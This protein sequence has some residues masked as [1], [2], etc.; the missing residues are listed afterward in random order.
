MSEQDEPTVP[1]ST[2]MDEIDPIGPLLR[3]AGP[4]EPVPVDR[5][6]RMR[7]AVHAE[8]RQQTRA[9]SRRAAFR[10]SLG[11]V[12]AA[13]LVLLGVRLTVRGGPEVP[14][15]GPPLAS[16]EAVNGAVRLVPATDR[17]TAASGTAASG[18]AALS[19][20]DAGRGIAERALVRVGDAVRAGD[21]VDTTDGGLAALR[22]AS[23]VAVR[24]DRETRLRLLSHVTLALDA[25]AI[26]VDS[27]GGA[28]GEGLE[29]RTPVGVARDIG[30]RFEVRLRG[31][32]L[33]VRV[34]DGVVR[35]SQGGQSH[36]VTLGEELT[37]AVD[38]RVDRRTIPV[39]GGEWAWA[40]SVARSFDIEGRSL[41]EFLTWIAGENGWQLRFANEAVERT[42]LAT[43][44]HGSIQGLTPEEALAA[45]LPTVGVEHQL[46]DGVLLVRLAA[47]VSKE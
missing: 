31:S 4:R 36:D 16:L 15:I 3:L 38:G 7:A 37:L 24:V 8:W 1:G 30:T 29:I 14:S 40:A 34:R 43:T 32:A 13:A 35:L 21:S 22:L 18:T 6:E 46:T 2:H 25:G 28:A 26:Y 27:G 41:R 33:R 12:A 42:S 19:G 39:F 45:V 20:T 47:A 23:G 10:W 11:A 44:L 17:G 5:L 9:R